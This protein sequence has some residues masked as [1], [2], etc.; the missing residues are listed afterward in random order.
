MQLWFLAIDWQFFVVGCRCRNTVVLLVLGSSRT[1]VILHVARCKRTPYRRRY[2]VSWQLVQMNQ[3]RICLS[4][5]AHFHLIVVTTPIAL[6]PCILGSQRHAVENLRHLQ[7]RMD[8][9]RAAAVG[10][11]NSEHQSP[12]A[13][14]EFEVLLKRSKQ[15]RQLQKINPYRYSSSQARI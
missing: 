13:F 6:L 1:T 11:F 14:E 5:N 4:C 15:F 9:T 3:E 7:L 10:I 12:S 2:I 8:C